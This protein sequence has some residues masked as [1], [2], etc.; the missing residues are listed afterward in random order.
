MGRRTMSEL[1]A[2]MSP[3]GYPLATFTPRPITVGR[4]VVIATAVLWDDDYGRY[5]VIGHYARQD[6]TKG[7]QTAKALAGAAEVP[8]DIRDAL[9]PLVQAAREKGGN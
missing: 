3:Y 1:H 7:G 5:R 6:G 2:Y 9:A 4:R 8:A